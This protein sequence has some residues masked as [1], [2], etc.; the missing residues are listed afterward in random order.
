MPGGAAA[1]RDAGPAPGEDGDRFEFR[2]FRRRLG[3]E[4]RILAA[5]AGAGPVEAG[6]DRYVVLPSPD[7]GLKVSGGALELKR[8]LRSRDRLELWHPQARLPLP[9]A[10]A[11][12]E[13]LLGLEARPG[14]KAVVLADAS[15][16]AAWFTRV[17]HRAV[18]AMRKRR[19]R[20]FV[21]GVRAEI[22]EI[23]WSGGRL[24]TLAVEGPC[25]GKVAALVARLGL[26]HLPNTSYPRLL[27][28][29]RSGRA[30]EPLV[31]PQP[32]TRP[33]GRTR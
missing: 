16:V 27:L 13:A 8:R 23:A 10:A 2:I 20:Y 33:N 11:E 1:A 17:Q 5:C 31:Q 28:D 24:E 22:G 21:A 18:V 19:R 15:A 12:I 26:G 29:G 7:L 30:D 9:M 14:R 3:A 25:P 4:A 32:S 6:L